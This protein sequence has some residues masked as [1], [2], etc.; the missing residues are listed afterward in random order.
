M[1]KLKQIEK[2]IESWQTDII[3]FIKQNLFKINPF[4]TNVSFL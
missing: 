1:E 4:S 2:Y 3:V